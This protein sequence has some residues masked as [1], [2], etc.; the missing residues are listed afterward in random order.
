LI[1]LYANI[2]LE[3]S[4]L[5]ALDM[6]RAR[7]T[8][9]VSFTTCSTDSATSVA[10]AGHP[11]LGSLEISDPEAVAETVS[12]EVTSSSQMDVV[13]RDSDAISEGESTLPAGL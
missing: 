12:A 9:K 5:H 2:L 11:A 13:H 1:Y 7:N 4:G 10:P 8:I 3:N 6:I